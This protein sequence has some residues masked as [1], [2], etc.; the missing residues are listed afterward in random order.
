LFERL[1]QWIE[2]RTGY[3]AIIHEALE[4][5]IPGGARW[6]YVFGSC[7]TVAFGLQLV[8][9]LLLMTTY[10]PS[11]TTAWGS[12]YFITNELHFG[13]FLRG[14]HH[15]GA[16]AMVV[17]LGLHLIQ[18]LLAGAYRA[19]REFNW[20][21]GL[22]LLV[23]TLG[24]GL[25]GYLLP[26]D[27]KGYWATKVA[28]N[29]MA[30]VPRIGPALQKIVVGGVDYGNQTITRFYALHVGILPLLL[31]LL[32]AAHVMLFRRHGV[33][34]PEHTRGVV[35]HFWPKQVF[36]DTVA[37]LIVF[38]VV[39]GLTLYE[40]F[41][42]HGIPL[43]APAD[44]ASA[45][46]PA[47]PEWYFL[48]LFQLLKDKRFSGE[49]EVIG[50][51]VVPTA[52][53]VVLTALPLLDKILPHRL[54]HFLACGLVFAIAGGAAYLTVEA[55]RAD[56][57]DPGFQEA[58][59]AAESA[60]HRSRVLAENVGIP[61]EG[62]GYLLRRD[63]LSQGRAVLERMCLGCHH[64]NGSGQVSRLQ[65]SLSSDDLA[66]A[67]EEPPIEG[68]PPE[69]RRALGAALGKVASSGAAEPVES[70]G[71][72]VAY[73]VQGTNEKG[74]AL[75]AR[76]S[77]DGRTVEATLNSKQTASD[78]WHY[79]SGEWVRGLLEA[80]GDKRYFGTVPQCGGMKRW[81]RESKLT[82]RDLNQIADFFVTKLMTI[83]EDLPASEWAERPDVQN[84]PAYKHFEEGGECALCHI[85]WV[86][87][88]EEAPNLYG[89]GSSWWIERLIKRPGAP[90]YFGYLDPSEQ[91]PPFGDKL[92][93]S[94]MK[95][96]I[97]YLKDDYLGAE[98][99]RGAD[100]RQPR[101][102][103]PL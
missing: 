43:D 64:Y 23:V 53:F 48:S 55:I 57:A 87:P 26:W 65:F 85:D 82:Q 94:D 38:A 89:W 14:L 34:H 5:P 8:T 80:P 18:V 100:S 35:D 88:N 27:Q 7:L 54:A 66:S 20:W 56:A 68:L 22:A 47:R 75:Q 32:T 61:P 62:A 67:G 17:L 60:A 70:G 41:R 63:P 28:T 52:I 59:R 25:T 13:W 58:R 49:N 31:I 1:S 95:A 37:V 99:P 36:F 92:T 19:P 86:Y 10:S 24:L 15:F 46:Y 21:I 102:V 72:V 45:N 76:V 4:E 29:I 90:H 97:R 51:V 42:G 6:R 12:V 74:D 78:L 81:K 9:G 91:M 79:G 16:Q 98:Q 71:R 77:A 44:P 69:A 2:S 73:R 83:P 40:Q 3:R 30:S 11:A 103:S 96:L 33:T 50:T 101:P 93:D 84:H 39:V